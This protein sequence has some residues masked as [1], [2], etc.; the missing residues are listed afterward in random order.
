MEELG[1]NVTPPTP[2]KLSNPELQEEKPSGL[3]IASMILGICSIIFR[4]GGLNLILGIVAVVL[5]FVEKKNIKDGDSTEAGGNFALTGII[6]GFAGIAL[7]A[8]MLISGLGL[9]ILSIIMEETGWS[10]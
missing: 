2:D 1:P 9:V 6:T 7:W 4:C 5:G 10:P 3:A 8:L